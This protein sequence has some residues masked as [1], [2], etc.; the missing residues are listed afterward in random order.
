[1]EK[2]LIS[3]PD[4]LAIRMRATIPRMQRS[5]IIAHLIEKEIEKRERTLYECALT[6]EHDSHLR[7][8]IADWDIT[9]NDGLSEDTFFIAKPSKNNAK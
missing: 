7:E 4:Q 1:M 9:M 5:K 8:E 6:V 3:I 2:V